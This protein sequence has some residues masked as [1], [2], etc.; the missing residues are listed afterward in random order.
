MTHEE[1][2][3]V[4]RIAWYTSAA[5]PDDPLPIAIAAYIKARG[6]LCEKEPRGFIV[7]DEPELGDFITRSAMASRASGM[8]VTDLH[9]PLSDNPKGESK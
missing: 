1:A 4:A 6:V 8:K 7:H 2:L 5:I 3:E 9:A